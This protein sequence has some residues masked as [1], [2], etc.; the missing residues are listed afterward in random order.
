MIEETTLSIDG[1]NED[2]FLV[3]GHPNMVEP[4]E[5][6]HRLNTTI[7]RSLTDRESRWP[8]WN[9]IRTDI[10]YRY[11]LAETEAAEMRTM[12]ATLGGK[13]MMVP[14]WHDIRLQTDWANRIYDPQWIV[15]VEGESIYAASDIGLIATDHHVCPLIL[16]RL[17]ERPK[18]PA[19]GE[20]MALFEMPF[21]EDSPW[22]CRCNVRNLGLGVVSF[23]A[24]EPDWTEV[25]DYSKDRLELIEVASSLRERVPYLENTSMRWAQDLHFTLDRSDFHTIA[26]FFAHDAGGRYRSFILDQKLKPHDQATPETPDGY[27]ARF[28][29]DELTVD[30][31]GAALAEA[32]L[33][34]LH[35]PWELNPPAGEEFTP[36]QY[37]WF[38]DFEWIIPDGTVIHYRYT[39]AEA[40]MS[41]DIDGSPETFE[42][43]PINHKGP[44][45][46]MDGKLG[47][48]DIQFATP[49]NPLVSW[50]RRQ[51]EGRLMLNLYK[52]EGSSPTG[53][54]EF[55]AEIG[56]VGLD[57]NIYK[58][59]FG[60]GKRRKA[61]RVIMQRK[62]NHSAFAP[63]GGIA[64]QSYAKLGDIAADP[65]SAVEI[66]V[67]I[68]SGSFSAKGLVGGW[69][70]VGSG[71]T[72]ESRMILDHFAVGGD[73]KIKLDKPL[74][75]A[76]VG[77]EVTIYPGYDRTWQS[78]YSDWG[79]GFGWANFLGF[80]QLPVV[81]P[82]VDPESPTAKYGGKK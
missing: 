70:H 37:N 5:L 47:S 2:I 52:G 57:R 32:T 8:R 15:D 30:F 65:S 42:A 68:T 81:D 58:G 76:G 38:Y 62:D 77:D 45:I 16:C 27:I 12:L 28:A 51:G 3:A 67:T 71:A 49:T 29:E 63:E 73:E 72:Y 22:D 40:D 33:R 34:F 80:P 18:A 43:E 56:E 31:S 55:R 10:I 64:Y 60:G 25:I 19:Y 41:V 53:E 26:S 23:P 75:H 46:G 4:V 59:S 13:R 1:Q 79:A 74:V 14:L 20:D 9:C 82:N 21:V 6:V 48:V 44:D 17:E 35:T 39:N 7:V 50:Y 24:I 11:D 54:L 78:C 36:D 69:L 66:F 61:P